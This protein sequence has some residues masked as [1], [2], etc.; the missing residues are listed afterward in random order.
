MKDS[1]SPEEFYLNLLKK[2]LTRYGFAEKY[3]KY[4]PRRGSPKR[5]LYAPAR[6]LLGLLKFELVR[7]KSVNP[8]DCAEG[9]DWALE[10][11]TMIRLR[12]LDNLQF[13]ITDL[14]RRQVPG[15]FIERVS[16]EGG[17]PFSCEVF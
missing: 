11:E 8:R 1:V 4:E 7:V 5:A 3:E 13:C 9:R 2:C 17:H 14:L 10:A 15:D 16:G 6:R 12:R